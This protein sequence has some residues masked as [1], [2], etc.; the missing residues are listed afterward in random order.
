MSNKRPICHLNLASAYGG[1][2]RQTELLVQELARRGV[3]QRL[4]V[5]ASSGLAERCDSVD[6]LETVVVPRSHLPAAR[7]IRG[8]ALAH[9]HDGRS[10]YA[11]LL[12]EIRYRIPYLVTRR[13]I[14]GKPIT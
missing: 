5:T 11:A 8:C 4:V 10:V 6:A 2:E 3:A 13:V 1:G 12:A 7:A 14:T 9:A